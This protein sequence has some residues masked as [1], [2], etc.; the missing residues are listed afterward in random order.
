[1]PTASPGS[2]QWSTAPHA[3]HIVHE[4]AK[5]EHGRTNNPEAALI[6]GGGFSRHAHDLGRTVAARRP[7]PA[8][9]PRS[10]SN[11][12]TNTNAAVPQRRREGVGHIS[13]ERRNFARRYPGRVD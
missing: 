6:G 13:S 1:M 2:P 5:N 7:E 3:C 11:A 9:V 4:G 10:P 12:P 8:G